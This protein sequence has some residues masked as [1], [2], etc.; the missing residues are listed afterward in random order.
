M[1]IFLDRRALGFLL[2]VG[3]RVKLYRLSPFFFS[4]TSL[5]KGPS[6]TTSKCFS[7]SQM[8]PSPH[9]SP[10]SRGYSRQL[11]WLHR[12]QTLRFPG[13]FHLSLFYPLSVWGLLESSFPVAT[14]FQ[15]SKQKMRKAEIFLSRSP[16][17]WLRYIDYHL[18]TSREVEQQP[19]PLRPPSAVAEHAAGTRDPTTEQSLGPAFLWF[20]D[21]FTSRAQYLV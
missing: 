1:G 12:I 19:L 2:A 9:S 11:T 20:G 17:F 5:P 7:I 18:G 8:F 6:H 13:T 4:P 10:Y 3:R 14:S 15:I 21:P 16:I